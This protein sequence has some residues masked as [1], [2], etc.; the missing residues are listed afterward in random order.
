MQ[1][2][3]RIIFKS[4]CKWCLL[5]FFSAA[6][7]DLND[8]MSDPLYIEDSAITILEDGE[9]INNGQSALRVDSSTGPLVI[10]A[11]SNVVIFV[12]FT[13]GKS[14]MLF[15]NVTVVEENIKQW[16]LEVADSSNANQYVDPSVS[17]FFRQLSEH[18][19]F[20][21]PSFCKSTSYPLY[22]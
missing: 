17:F 12:T 6:V 3:C 18:P 20:S 13:D 14:D 11:K 8:G 1:V 15:K 10:N 5:I 21:T 7:C 4:M 16:K 19:F 2:R 9:L 22:T